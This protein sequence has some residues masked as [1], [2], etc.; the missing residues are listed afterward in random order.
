MNQTLTG[1]PGLKVGHWTDAA[2]RTGCTVVLC[3]EEGC[4]ASAAFLGPA[5]GTREGVLLSPEKSVQR[6]H[7]LIL[8]GGSAFGLAAADGVV[9][10]LHERKIGLVT[11]AIRVPIVPAAVIYDLATGN[12]AWP[13]A[14]AGYL[15]AI[16]ASADE[17]L[18]GAVGAGTGATAG[19]Y[20]K[21]VDSGLGSALMQHGEILVGALAVVNPVGDIY[22][23]DGNLLL[24]HG[25]IE[26][27][28]RASLSMGHTTL[29]V[30]GMEAAIDKAGA[31]ALAGAAQAAL[32]RVI[33]PSHTAWDGD[34]VFVLSTQAGPEVSPLLLGALVQE[35]VA[36]AVVR[37]AVIAAGL[38]TGRRGE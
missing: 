12:V 2:S 23:L 10:Y 30:V 33:R 19:K 14:E 31:Y 32:G 27:F 9:R 18:E 1:V 6:V 37:A 26:A 36:G 28:Y 29:V 16:A 22:G 38:H 15:A 17:V 11:P 8:A 3:P 5:P 7:G 34:S 13:T 20:L 25:R 24:G 21:P 35:A 4:L